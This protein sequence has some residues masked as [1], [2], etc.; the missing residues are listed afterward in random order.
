MTE[1]IDCS[2]KQLDI[3]DLEKKKTKEKDF[4][5]KLFEVKKYFMGFIKKN[6]ELFLN[7]N[8]LDTKKLKQLCLKI[9]NYLEK[10]LVYQNFYM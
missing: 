2:I 4:E 9:M 10:K 5:S 3:S 8:D 1:P 6:S 7:I